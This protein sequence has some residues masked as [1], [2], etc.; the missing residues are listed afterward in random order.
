MPLMGMNDRVDVRGGANEAGLE[1]AG[2]AP[3]CEPAHG[4][5][6]RRT[7]NRWIG[8]STAPHSYL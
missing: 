8:S 2:S 6:A 1:G 5:T 3:E 7:S 4:V